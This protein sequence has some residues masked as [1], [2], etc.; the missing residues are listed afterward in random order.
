M[1]HGLH[2]GSQGCLAQMAQALQH[3]HSRGIGHM[4]VKPDNIL[5]SGDGVY[6]LGDFGLARPLGSCEGA[7]QLEEG[8]SRWLQARVCG[9]LWR[10]LVHE[11]HG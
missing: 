4:D 8:D 7:A 11:V 1:L 10:S 6:K 9:L 2:I 3:L 5:T